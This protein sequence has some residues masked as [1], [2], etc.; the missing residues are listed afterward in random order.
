MVLY[1]LS[2]KKTLNS[3]KFYDL[4]PHMFDMTINLN[5]FYTEFWL[6]LRAKQGVQNIKFILSCGFVKL[7]K[8]WI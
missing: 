4:F 7:F 3:Y 8:N 5:K 2:K 6:K 1:N